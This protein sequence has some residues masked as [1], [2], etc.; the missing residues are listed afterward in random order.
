MKEQIHINL[1][2]G[3]LF[4]FFREKMNNFTIKTSYNLEFICIIFFFVINDLFFFNNICFMILKRIKKKEI[5]CCD[6]LK[7]TKIWM[8]IILFFKEGF[9]FFKNDL[10]WLTL[11]KNLNLNNEWSLE[12]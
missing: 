1:N 4:G 11:S 6:D 2:L 7:K 5:L 10:L 8:K 12:F 3:L 9:Y